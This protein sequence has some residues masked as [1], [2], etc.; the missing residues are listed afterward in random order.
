MDQIVLDVSANTVIH[1]TRVGG[2]L[3]LTGWEHDQFLAEADDD[4]SL[5]VDHNEGQLVLSASSDVTVR[6]PRA[7]PIVIDNIGNDAQ[8]KSLEGALRI[9]QV[10]NEL[11]LRQVAD[12]DIERV[13]DDLSA[14]KIAGYLRVGN[15]GGDLLAHRVQGDFAV[16]RAGNDL[17]LRDVEG[18]IQA[19]AGNDVTLNVEF[20]PGHTYAVEAGGDLAC[21]LDPDSDG[22]FDVR[23][24]GDLS[25]AVLGAQMTGN[26]RHK[27]VTLGSGNPAVT[28]AAGGDLNL[29]GLAASP[30]TLDDFGDR[31]GEDFGVMAEEFAAQIE[32]QIESQIE[33]QLADFQ[34][35][36]SE[37]LSGLD[38]GAVH[39]KAEELAAKARRAAERQSENAKRRIERQTEAAQRRVEV[40]QRRAE[41]EAERAR[42]HVEAAQRRA[43]AMARRS[44]AGRSGSLLEVGRPSGWSF[45]FTGGPRPPTPPAPPVPPTPPAPPAAPVSDEERM[46]ILRMVEQGKITVADAEQ[47]LA[48][49]EGK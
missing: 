28:L 8:I 2:D 15:V 23:A 19:V 21:R 35:Q 44:S 20:A 48:A 39:F 42:R 7:A 30:D 49:L 12:T 13:G 18:N 3:R 17:F 36:L 46:V 14:K 10:G 11:R 40:A 9:R 22:L 24:G 6:V 1:I 34:R 4:N 31:F 26:G 45:G 16:G 5:K 29:S 41:R 33:V 32:N 37:K 27:V 25:V 38:V 47:L 43:E